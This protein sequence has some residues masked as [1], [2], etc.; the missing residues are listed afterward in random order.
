MTDEQAAYPPDYIKF[1]PSIACA[2]EDDALLITMARVLGLCWGHRYRKSP[3]YTPDQ[4]AGL[5]GRPRTTLYRHL[6]RLQQL[7]W[8]KVEHRD[9]RLVLQPLV[10]IAEG[11]AAAPGQALARLVMLQD[12]VLAVEGGL[13]A[14]LG[15]IQVAEG[16]E[17]FVWHGS[18]SLRSQGRISRLTLCR[19]LLFPGQVYQQPVDPPQSLL[20]LFGTDRRPTRRNCTSTHV[21]ASNLNLCVRHPL[22]AE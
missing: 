12:D 9:R 13:H 22:D 20:L 2:N 18:P 4:L 19:G 11:Q 17:G 6:N 21:C 5:L 1:P 15:T 8:L 10:R 7:R 16:V 14:H 3:P